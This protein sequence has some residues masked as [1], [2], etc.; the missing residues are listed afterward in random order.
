MFDLSPPSLNE[1]GMSAAIAD[2]LEVQIRRPYNIKTSYVNELDDH[3]EE[4]IEESARA[5]L[6]RNVRELLINVVKH[7]QAKKVSVHLKQSDGRMT[8]IIEDDGIGFDTHAAIQPGLQGGG[9]GLFSIQERMTDLEGT[10]DVAS[11]PGMG[12]RAVLAI[13][14][15]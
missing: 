13:P 6:F 11:A 5:I 14:L 8:I 15:G 2:W 10:F 3:F 1:L 9:F 4:T 12:C 7:A